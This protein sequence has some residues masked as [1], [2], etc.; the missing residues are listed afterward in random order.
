MARR[1]PK[2]RKERL[3]LRSRLGKKFTDARERVARRVNRR[4][5]RTLE[6]KS[7]RWNLASE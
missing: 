4:G 5:K 6:A 1:H 2:S 7:E 3:A